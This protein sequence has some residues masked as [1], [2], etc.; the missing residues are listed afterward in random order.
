M[1]NPRR[2]DWQQ[3]NLIF[4]KTIHW[5]DPVLDGE[6]QALSSWLTLI[7]CPVINQLTVPVKNMFQHIHHWKKTDKFPYSLDKSM[8]SPINVWG[9]IGQCRD[10]IRFASG[11]SPWSRG[12][13]KWSPADKKKP[14]RLVVSDRGTPSYHPFPIGSMYGIYSSIGGILMV[15]VTIYTIHGSYGF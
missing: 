5:V 6:T 13:C 1:L 11:R 7:I 15:N 14:P 4:Q 2:M 8:F 3:S 9:A 12:K 10:A